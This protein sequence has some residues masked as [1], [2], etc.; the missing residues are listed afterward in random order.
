MTKI[1]SLN[2]QNDLKT[3]RNGASDLEDEEC[4]SCENPD[5]DNDQQ[6]NHSFNFDD[7][8]INQGNSIWSEINK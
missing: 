4:S 2:L 8:N 7:S 1:F 3:S 5:S 6:N